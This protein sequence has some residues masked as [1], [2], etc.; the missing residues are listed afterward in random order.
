MN[1]V[2]LSVN[3]TT[4][5]FIM[6]SENRPIFSGAYPSRIPVRTQA[7]REDSAMLSVPSEIRPNSDRILKKG[8]VPTRYHSH[9]ECVRVG[10]KPKAGKRWAAFRFCP[11]SNDHN[12]PTTI[13]HSAESFSL[14]SPFFLYICA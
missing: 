8:P 11:S 4:P 7:L 6:L 13:F 5:V 9:A 2:M 10:M 14:T 12:D 3:R 1:S